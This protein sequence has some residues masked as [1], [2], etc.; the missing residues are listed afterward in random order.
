LSIF[1]DVKKTLLDLIYVSR[2]RSVPEGRIFSIIK[3]YGTSAKP[4]K[5]GAYLSSPLL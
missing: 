5:T 2:Y 3:E 1:S 4:G